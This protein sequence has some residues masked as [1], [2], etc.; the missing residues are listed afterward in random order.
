VLRFLPDAESERAASVLMGVLGNVGWKMSAAIPD[1]AKYLP[2]FDGVLVEWR[3]ISQDEL[4][5]MESLP[6]SNLEEEAARLAKLRKFGE[7]NMQSSRAAEELVD[8][9]KANGWQARE[10]PAG[11]DELPPDSIGITVGFKPNP[12]FDPEILK[13]INDRMEQIRQQQLEER[14]RMEKIFPP[15]N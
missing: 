14:R 2:F 9:L 12:Y 11:Q 8:F 5:Q 4:R 1:T 3:T 15:G 10:M 13:E 6:S 7:E